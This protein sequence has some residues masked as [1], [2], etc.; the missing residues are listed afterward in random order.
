MKLYTVY[1]MSNLSGYT[2]QKIYADIRRL[3]IQEIKK[4]LRIKYYTELQMHIILGIVKIVEIDVNWLI[5]ES[6]MNKL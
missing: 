4:E 5:I 2:A 6:K 1:E 3:G